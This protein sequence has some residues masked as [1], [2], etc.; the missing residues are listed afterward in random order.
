[1]IAAHLGASKKA[2]QWHVGFALET[3]NG[4][5]HAQEKL[6][7]KNFDL[8]VLNSPKEEGAAFQHDTNSVQFFSASGQRG[9]TGLAPKK[10][11]AFRILEELE[12]VL[13]EKRTN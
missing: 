8:V 9:S 1:M 7:K 13:E 4:P 3:E 10:E 5:A 11:I 6:E 12:S 2:G